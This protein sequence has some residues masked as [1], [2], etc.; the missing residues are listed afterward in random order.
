MM[1][2]NYNMRRR[3]ME[4]E[5]SGRCATCPIQG[6]FPEVCRLHQ[7]QMMRKGLNGLLATNHGWV[8]WGMRIATG[9]GLGLAGAMAGLAVVPV[10]GAKAILGHMIGYQI[11]GA[12]SATGA[13]VNVA[14]KLKHKGP[15]PNKKRIKSRSELRKRYARLPYTLS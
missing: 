14:M 3:K 6:R 10:F 9:A 4:M 1:R 12:V 13:G 7:E 5:M 2:E 8:C 11:A 15:M